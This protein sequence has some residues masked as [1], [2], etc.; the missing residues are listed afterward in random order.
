MRWHRLPPVVPVVLVAASLLIL[1]GCGGEPEPAPS[2]LPPYP[3]TLSAASTPSQVAQVLIAALDAKDVETLT[4]L[5]AARHA[6]DD[7]D[8]IYES[9]GRS[10]ETPPERAAQTLVSGWLLS[11]AWFEPGRTSVVSE[12]IRGTT[13]V[14]QAEGLNPDTGNTR[15]LI[16]ELVQE[17]GVWKGIG[18][19]KSREP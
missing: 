4:A 6:A 17:D 11:Y 7:I 5:V 2:A 3:S 9:H 10:H 15:T 12:Q 18:G 19:V 1:S 8:Q 14:V 16:I 13:A